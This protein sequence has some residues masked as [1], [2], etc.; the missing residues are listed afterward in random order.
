LLERPWY[1]R[2]YQWG[3]AHVLHLRWWWD[4]R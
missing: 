2:L 4:H 3:R 1:L